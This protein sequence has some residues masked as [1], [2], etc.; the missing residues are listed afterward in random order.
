MLK[1]IVFLLSSQAET[2]YHDKHLIIFQMRRT[3]KIFTNLLLMAMFGVGIATIATGC[4]SNRYITYQDGEFD[5]NEASLDE[6]SDI[7]QLNSEIDLDDQER[8]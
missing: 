7:F 1:C 2:R 3:V 4:N 6:A 8:Y 5:D